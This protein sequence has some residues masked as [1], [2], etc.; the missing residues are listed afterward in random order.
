V[1]K[2]ADEV[3]ARNRLWELLERRR[4]PDADVAAID[5]RI[6]E[7]FGETWTVMFT[8]LAGFSRMV[9]EFGIIHFLQEIHDQR[10]ILLPVVARHEGILVKEEADSMLLLFQR[11]DEA[12]TCAIEMQHRC[13]AANVGR[14]PE[15][16]VL[17]CIGLGHGRVLHIGD[18]D[19]FGQEVNAASKL[20]EDTAKA[21][22][23]LITDAVRAAAGELPGVT[24]EKIDAAVAGSA[25]NFRVVYPRLAKAP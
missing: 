4:R 22:E 12:I 13:Q 18:H 5:A 11:A 2:S 7:A 9:A 6:W 16:A 24:F 8:D 19:V 14:A 25:T 20:G 3:P 17:L 10:S 21:N 23:I 1:V 15:N